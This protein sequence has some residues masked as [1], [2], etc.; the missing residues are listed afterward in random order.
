[1]KLYVYGFEGSVAGGKTGNNQKVTFLVSKWPTVPKRRKKMQ[2]VKKNVKRGVKKCLKKK[3]SGEENEEKR[4]LKK[5]R[6]K[7][8]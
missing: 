7:R 5:G 4:R 6:R 2:E 3:Q 8:R 1:M